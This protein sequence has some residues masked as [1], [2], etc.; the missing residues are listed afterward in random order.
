MPH[1]IYCERCKQNLVSRL[2]DLCATCAK[3]VRKQKH[4]DELYKRLTTKP[5]S[6]KDTQEDVK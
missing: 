2:G 4:P 3:I 5:R 1:I 6:P